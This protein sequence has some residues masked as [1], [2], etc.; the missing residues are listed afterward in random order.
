MK[1]HI[2][3]GD[4]EIGQ[5][6]SVEEI[7]A[8]VGFIHKSTLVCLEGLD[9]SS[10]AN[11]RPAVCYPELKR[12]LRDDDTNPVAPG[13]RSAES[14]SKNLRILSTDDDPAIRTLL[15]N[16]LSEEGHY[17]EFAKDGLEVFKR[18][19]SAKYDLLILDVNMPGMNGY[20]VAE[21]LTAGGGLR[22]KILL[23]TGRDTDA[24]KFQFVCSGADAILR[25]GSPL[26][27]ITETIYDIVY[28]KA[29]KTADKPEEH[30][31]P[32]EIQHDFAQI[33]ETRS[34]E[35]EPEL[36]QQAEKPHP[37]PEKPAAIATPMAA[38]KVSAP[39]R[40]PAPP[41]P[42]ENRPVPPPPPAVRIPH[43][44]VEATPD[45]P[46][47]ASAA[48]PDKSVENSKLELND[49]RLRLIGLERL[50]HIVLTIL[51]FSVLLSVY[52]LIRQ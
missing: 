20:K 6:Q 42:P 15:W 2:S 40:P 47:R 18:L 45:E 33:Q 50:L 10:A 16:L 8:L 17:L 41:P 24:E 1:F 14:P 49:F 32:V 36:R 13:A 35:P 9:I 31:Q 52:S 43:P 11:W 26:E 46:V 28:A 21:K 22:P 19:K 12:L 4:V 5:P 30:G 25:K 27:L 29:V 7:E 38:V 37:E 48:Q 34:Q 39:Q 23:F 51:L 3:F 44:H